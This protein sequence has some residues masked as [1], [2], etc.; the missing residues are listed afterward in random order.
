[1]AGLDKPP[2]SIVV[3]STDMEAI[4]AKLK[5]D[6]FREAKPSYEQDRKFFRNMKW[7]RVTIKFYYEGESIRLK[8][9]FFNFRRYFNE[10]I[11]DAETGL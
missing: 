6:R 1:M 2:Q 5:A 8:C 7:G 11:N 10:F 4:V 9:N 3:K